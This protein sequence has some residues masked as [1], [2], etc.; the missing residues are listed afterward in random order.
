MLDLSLVN[1][2]LA[3]GAGLAS[4][5]S[6]CVLPVVP[7][8][9]TG[10]DQ[11]SK[12]RPVAIVAGLAIAF[13]LM[14]VVGAVFGSVVLSHMTWMERAAGVLIGLFGV[15]M[16]F[17]VNL[18]KGVSLF[19]KVPEVTRGGLL[20]ATLLGASLGLVWIPCVGP[21]LSSVLAVVATSG[22]VLTG[23]VLLLVYSLGF[24]APM[25]AVAYG[26]QVFRQRFRSLGSAPLALRALS[27]LVLVA[28]GAWVFFK[29]AI[30]VV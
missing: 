15:L 28:L 24:A 5:L 6:P 4:I 17:D 22:K 27:G 12:W 1:L 8:I 16:L 7:I 10:T 21:M 18:F 25:L 14:G 30:L 2:G 20:G 3:F 9:V 26:S 23:T 11:D 19:R 13:V 29:G